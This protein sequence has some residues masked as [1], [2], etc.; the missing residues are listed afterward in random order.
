MGALSARAALRTRIAVLPIYVEN[1]VE[2][3]MGKA[4]SHYRRMV[5]F[6][7]RELVNANFEVLNPF[8][9]DAAEKELNRTLQR[10]RARDLSG[11][12]DPDNVA[13]KNAPGFE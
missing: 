5:G 6:I 12:H 10:A 8:A 7:N 1:G 9:Q 3:N 13:R 2:V 4:A 11:R